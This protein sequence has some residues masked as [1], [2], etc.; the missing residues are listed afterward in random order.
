[1]AEEISGEGKRTMRF[2]ISQ[3]K[4]LFETTSSSAK[5]RFFREKHEKGHFISGKS[6][7]IIRLKRL[8]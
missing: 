6:Q 7:E 8:K 2:H 1:L 5:Q 3:R 4:V